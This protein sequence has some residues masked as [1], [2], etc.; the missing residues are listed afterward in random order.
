MNPT[1]TRRLRRATAALAMGWGIFALVLSLGALRD[2]EGL[3]GHP[4]ET[5]RTGMMVTVEAVTSPGHDSRIERGDELVAVNGVPFVWA[6]RR[7]SA[8]SSC[9]R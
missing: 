1:S 5:V 8:T 2:P 7:G 4:F 6:L 9:R 3:L